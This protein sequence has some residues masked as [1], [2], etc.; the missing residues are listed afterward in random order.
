[1]KIEE[2]PVQVY[3]LT[4]EDFEKGKVY[5]PDQENLPRVF[6]ATDEAC[7]V[8]LRNGDQWPFARTDSWIRNR[9]W[10]EVNAKVVIE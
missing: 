10:R 1:M 9:A 3:P 5:S 8:D 6:I 7:L 2:K 4:F